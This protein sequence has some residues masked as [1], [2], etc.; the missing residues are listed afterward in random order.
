MGWGGVDVGVV[1][2]VVGFLPKEE[3]DFTE[4]IAV[5]LSSVFCDF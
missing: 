4:R 5:V 1:V 3:Q 2:L